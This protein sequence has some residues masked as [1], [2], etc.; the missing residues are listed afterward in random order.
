VKF[1]GAWTTSKTTPVSITS[2]FVLIP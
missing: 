1:R 2:D